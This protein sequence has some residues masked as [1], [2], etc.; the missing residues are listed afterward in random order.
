MQTKTPKQ[1]LAISVRL[2]INHKRVLERHSSHYKQ[3]DVARSLAHCY[4]L[5][6]MAKK[7]CANFSLK[8][9]CMGVICNKKHLKNILP[10]VEHNHYAKQK[11]KLDLIIATAN[12]LIS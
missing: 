11:Q 12:T 7:D 10:R 2:Y 6:L 8:Q 5:F 1:Q 4:S 3:P 9:L